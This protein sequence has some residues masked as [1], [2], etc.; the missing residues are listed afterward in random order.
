MGIFANSA[1]AQ[2]IP[3]GAYIVQPAESGWSRLAVSWIEHQEW[4]KRC[5]FSVDFDDKGEIVKMIF[6]GGSADMGTE[7]SFMFPCETE[8]GTFKNLSAWK[9]F[10]KKALGDIVI[11]GDDVYGEKSPYTFVGLS[12]AMDHWE[13]PSTLQAL[14]FQKSGRLL[15]VS[16]NSWKGPL[17][18][19]PGQSIL[20]G[21]TGRGQYFFPMATVAGE[22]QTST[23]L[24]KQLEADKREI[25]ILSRAEKK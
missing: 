4:P 21:Q 14:V 1:S 25:E 15:S 8:K 12:V 9:K 5:S 19:K 10:A 18:K 20:I 7:F 16:L 24:T 6:A 22:Y 17:P 11:L 3:Q 13:T 23:E 2:S